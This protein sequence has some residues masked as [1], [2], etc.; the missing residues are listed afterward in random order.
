MQKIVKHFKR[1]D[2]I[3]YQ[4]SQKIHSLEL[5]EK[6]ENF[7]SD[8][9]EAIINQQ[10]SEK[11][12][13]TIFQR[14]TR[15]FPKGKISPEKLL[16]IPDGQIRN[17]GPSN[18]KV[19]FLKDLATKVTQKELELDKLRELE[20]DLVIKTLMKVKGIGPWTAEMFLMFS[21]AREDVFSF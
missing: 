21:L 3:L 14:F 2:P 4:A 6:S 1:V 10:L 7:F 19:T 17:V 18:A 9:C 13:D 11:A 5:L 16:L 8:L 20:N 15:L 12:G